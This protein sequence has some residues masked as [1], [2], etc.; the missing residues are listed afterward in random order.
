MAEIK[1]TSRGGEAVAEVVEETLTTTMIRCTSLRGIDTTKAVTMM[2]DTATDLAL[3]TAIRIEEGTE[4]EGEAAGGTAIVEE[5][6][7]HEANGSHMHPHCKATYNTLLLCAFLFLEN[8]A[9]LF[10]N[11]KCCS[12]WQC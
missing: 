8:L 6:V 11:L 1:A 10:F 9:L 2:E 7:S 4:G 12:G 5:E 3:A